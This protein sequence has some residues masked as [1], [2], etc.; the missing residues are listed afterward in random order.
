MIDK[1]IVSYLQQYG[2]RFTPQQL[3]KS[4]MAD[5]WPLAEIEAAMAEVGLG[6]PPPL[7]FEQKWTKRAEERSGMP[8]VSGSR[9]LARG[10]PP[11]ETRWASL[12]ER[13]APMASKPPAGLGQP[14]RKKDSLLERL[15][16]GRKNGL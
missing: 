2:Q 6:G 10:H 16:R 1:R 13:V 5:G 8:T 4:L 9:P 14:E 3:K 12:D 15:L 7:P 11:L